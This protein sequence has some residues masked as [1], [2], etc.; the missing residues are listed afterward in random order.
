MAT[1]SLPDRPAALPRPL[2]PLIGR[3]RDIAAVRDLLLRDDVRLV[4]LTGP[5][6]IGKTRLAIAVAETLADAFEGGVR[7]VPLEAIRDAGLVPSV[8][9]L[10]FGV[11]ETARQPLVET[12]AEGLRSRDALLVLDNFEQILPAA[13][14][15][16]ELLTACPSLT[17]LVTSRVSLNLYG[18]RAVLVPSL[19]LAEPGR[20][21]ASVP[22]QEVASVKL[23]AQRAGAVQS[24][25]RLTDENLA[26]VAAICSR[27]DGLPLAIELAAARTR[28]LSPAALLERLQH[29]LPLLAGGARNVAERH[30]TLR[31]SIAW[32]YG[33][34]TASEQH[35]FRQLAVFIGGWT[36]EAAEAICTP[37]AGV[38][39]GLSALVDHS[40]VRQIEQRDGTLRFSMLETIREFAVEQLEASSEADAVAKRHA[41]YFAAFPVPTLPTPPV[42]FDTPERAARIEADLAN[43][44]AAF[45]WLLAREPDAAV[46]LVLDL[47][48]FWAVRAYYSEACRWLEATLADSV[49][50]SYRARSLAISDLADNVVW[51]GDYAQAERLATDAL[52]RFE[53]LHDSKGIG[54]ALFCLARAVSFASDF[55]R[56][57]ELYQ[58]VIDVKRELGDWFGIA[59]AIGNMG[60]IAQE[61]GDLDHAEQLLLEALELTRTHDFVSMSSYWLSN[62]GYLAL[63]RGDREGAGGWLAE[64]LA[65]AR[66]LHGV[67]TIVDC[68]DGFAQCA[69]EDG[70]SVRATRL[71]TASDA[72]R[73]ESGLALFSFSRLFHERMHQELPSILGAA[74]FD[75]AAA[76]GCAMSLDEAID[77]ALAPPESSPADPATTGSPASLLS[78]RELE[79]LRLLAEGQTNQE[80]AAA[81]FISPNT[82][83]NHVASILNKLGL[84]SRTAVATYAVRH[85]LV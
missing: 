47:T 62:L 23:F 10:A 66:E 4:T 34:L 18:E 51:L 71:L 45:A 6:G 26:A 9:A 68:L 40:L 24:D 46:H 58:R 3:E 81:L 39:D 75:A 64:A 79:V 16:D 59:G 50:L 11:R 38:F 70:Q 54:D 77:Y 72:L 43:L 41:A 69:H 31:A 74:A 2:T 60:V 53:E 49:A 22:L 29:P 82:V 83:N 33:L 55:D 17:V 30:Q 78:R 80:I 84:D 5:G 65:L 13:S 35:L 12:L 63:Q 15:V 67:R 32:S 52:E 1:A 8:V 85:G 25:F 48:A 73:Q 42:G 19:A 28:M 56:G 20:A 37:A 14:F 7:F 44:R 61:Q 57:I 76:E 21:L 27:L 36:L